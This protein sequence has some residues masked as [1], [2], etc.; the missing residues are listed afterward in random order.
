VY[1]QKDNADDAEDDQQCAKQALENKGRHRLIIRSICRLAAFRN[2]S[3]RLIIYY[4]QHRKAVC[5][6]GE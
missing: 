6:V 2:I 5:W 4:D 1:Q 3:L